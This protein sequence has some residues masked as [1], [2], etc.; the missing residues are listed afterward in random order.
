MGSQEIYDYLKRH[1]DR[2]DITVKE[3]CAEFNLGQSSVNKV[4]KKMVK[5]H[6]VSIK[7]EDRKYLIRL[8]TE[9]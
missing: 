9:D 5:Y 7:V 4:I 2:K 8:R 3:L 1:K 6:E